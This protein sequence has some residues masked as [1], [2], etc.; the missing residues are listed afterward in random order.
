MAD[1]VQLEIKVNAET[2]QLEVLGAKFGELAGKAGGAQT[3]FSKLGGEAGNLL[4][5]FLPL[6]T[7]GGIIAFFANAV[8]G[9]EEENESLRRLKFTLESSGQS[10]DKNKQSIQD[11]SQAIQNSTRFSDSEALS[12][13][14]KLTRA[15]GNAA[16]AQKAAQLAISLSVASGQDLAS[17][18][19]LVN[20]LINKQERAVTLAHRQFGTYVQNA[21]TAQ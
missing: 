1:R 5:S 14:D 12:S 7:A 4:K 2:G 10:W 18:T 16:Q 17:A 15:T 21:N 19:E 6:A 13:L 11:W 9:A 3:A 8:K 20:N